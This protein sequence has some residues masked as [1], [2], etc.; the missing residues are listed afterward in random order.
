MF[1][2]HFE[3]SCGKGMCGRPSTTIGFERRF[4]PVLQLSAAGFLDME[5]EL[6]A[7]PLNMQAILETNQG[8][9]DHAWAMPHD[10]HSHSI[11]SVSAQEAPAWL[12]AHP[13]RVLDVREP[14]EYVSG[15]IPGAVSI[16]Q[17]EL[18]TRLD[19]VPREG[20]LLVVC[21]SGIR[22]LRAASFL[23]QV[24]YARV[25]NLAGGTSGWVAAGHPVER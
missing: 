22:S 5:S 2:A 3:G 7:R 17:A 25:T 19:E 23:R 4:N 18:A 12:A 16:P 8:L 13:A 20:E 6:P 10:G 15:H 21:A 11:P 24:G 1:P 9:A 14:V